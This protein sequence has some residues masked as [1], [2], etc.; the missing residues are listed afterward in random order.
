MNLPYR[1]KWDLN[2]LMIWLKENNMRTPLF[3][4]YF[5]ND[6]LDIIDL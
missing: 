5:S 2:D 1:K 6:P 4:N 3:D